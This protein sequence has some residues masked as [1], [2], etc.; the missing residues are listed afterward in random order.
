MDLPKNS[1]FNVVGAKVSDDGYD[2]FAPLLQPGVQRKLPQ[3]D[4]TQQ[5]QKLQKEQECSKKRRA[6]KF[7]MPPTK[8]HKPLPP[9]PLFPKDENTNPN[10]AKT[11]PQHPAAST[12]SFPKSIAGIACNT[13]SAAQVEKAKRATTPVTYVFGI[14][15]S[16]DL[17]KINTLLSGGKSAFRATRS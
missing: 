17:A 5:K 12:N 2:P 7:T 15:T 10:N 4:Q 6:E 14:S 13:L 9:V 1:V 8:R 11:T 3:K 16:N